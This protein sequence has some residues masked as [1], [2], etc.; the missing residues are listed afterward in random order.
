[1]FAG[2]CV[3]T[4]SDLDDPEKEARVL[5]EFPMLPTGPKSAWAPLARQYAGDNRGM[6]YMPEVGD[7]ALVAFEHGDFDHPF[8]I[9]F[10]WNGKDKPPVDGI[11]E[12]VRRIQTKSGHQLDLDDRKGDEAIVI[13]TAGG[14]TIELRDKST[15]VHV[16]ITTTGGNTIEMSDKPSDVHITLATTAGNKIEMSDKPGSSHISLSTTA[17]QNIEIADTPVPSITVSAAMGKVSVDCL[18]ATVQ[19]SSMLSVTAPMTTFSGVVQ[20]QTLIASTVVGTTYTP[21]VGNIW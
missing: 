9:G 8:V 20:V 18:Q 14:N 3:A 11:D 12:H 15:D 6:Y 4:V 17:G 2:V 13:K 10:L 21:G 5:V 7:E 19:A 1:M 16:T